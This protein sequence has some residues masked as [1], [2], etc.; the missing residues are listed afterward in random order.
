MNR[1]PRESLRDVLTGLAP[2]AFGNCARLYHNPACHSTP[3]PKEAHHMATKAQAKAA[4]EALAQGKPNP[5]QPA[6]NAD[7]SP[8]E[9]TYADGSTRVGQ[10]PFPEKSPLQEKAD[11]VRASL[12]TTLDTTGTITEFKPGTTTALVT[13]EEDKAALRVGYWLTLEPLAGDPVAMD[14][15]RGLGVQVLEVAPE[16]VIQWD[17]SATNVAGLTADYVWA[18]AA[19]TVPEADASPD[20]DHDAALTAKQQAVAPEIPLT[21]EMQSEMDRRAR[22]AADEPPPRMVTRVY[23]DGSERRG[24]EPF[25]EESPMQ[26][27]A[28]LKREESELIDPGVMARQEAASRRPAGLVSADEVQRSPVPP[29]P[30]ADNA[31]VDGADA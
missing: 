8:V 29:T 11:L 15:I 19:P 28:R 16:V 24:A 2:L 7:G 22:V 26:E 31:A 12:D 18:D 30:S 14:A 27:A 4:L 1:G 10:P 9:Y 21:P 17:S 6:P 23:P 3:Q 13:D 25:P 20:V 5:P